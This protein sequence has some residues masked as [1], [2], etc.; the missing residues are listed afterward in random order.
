MRSF[1]LLAALGLLLT[2]LT[3][4]APAGPAHAGGSAGLTLTAKLDR[5]A[6]SAPRLLTGT[7]HTVFVTVTD[8][9]G[10]A[11][12]RQIRVDVADLESA[13]LAVSCDAGPNG[14]MSLELH[15]SLHCTAEFSAETGARTIVVTATAQAPGLGSVTR[16]STLHYT[17]FLPPPPPSPAAPPAAVSVPAHHSSPL[18][19]DTAKQADHRPSSALP[20]MTPT[21]GGPPARNPQAADCSGGDDTA[22]TTSASCCSGSGTTTF[23][24]SSSCCPGGM[25]ADAASTAPCTPSGHDARSLRPT[26]R[27]PWA[28]L[29]LPG[30]SAPLLGAAAAAV[31]CAG[32]GLV[33]LGRRRAARR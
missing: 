26:D 2:P 20:I 25:K 19:P 32:A 14:A 11:S 5:L 1:R 6:D 28:G 31:A 16:S 8:E 10:E 30:T 12:L 3:V 23:T 33:W 21:A 29:A 24:A 9:P 13:D 7:E 27:G 15:Q 18:L 4:A 17:G 22:G